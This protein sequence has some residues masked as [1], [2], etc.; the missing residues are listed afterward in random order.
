[1]STVTAALFLLTAVVTATLGVLIGQ[2]QLMG[3][4]AGYDPDQV[5]DD[6]GLARFVGT[7]TLVIA[8]LSAVVGVLEFARPDGGQPVVY[9]LYTA[10]L[11]AIAGYLVYGSRRY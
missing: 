1:M 2:F 3:L 4:I 9:G 7:Y 10:A 11:V 6:E 5:T 8:G